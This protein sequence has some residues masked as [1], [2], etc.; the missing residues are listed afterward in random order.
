MNEIRAAYDR[1]VGTINHDKEIYYASPKN[2]ALVRA[3]LTSQGLA[4]ETWNEFFFQS[5]ILELRR[6]NALEQ[7]PP[8]KTREEIS[9]ER[10]IRDRSAARQKAEGPSQALKSIQDFVKKIDE[11]AARAVERDRII[12]HYAYT[13]DG[14]I[15]HGKTRAERLEMAKKSGITLED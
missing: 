12:S 6:Q 10:E 14:R 4:P 13:P 2:F 7:R 15:N 11:K 1:A 9:R 5:A 8:E 3:F